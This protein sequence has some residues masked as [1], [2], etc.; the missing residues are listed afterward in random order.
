[1]KICLWLLRMGFR[2][3]VLPADFFLVGFLLQVFSR[4]FPWCS[5]LLVRVRCA[6]AL[7]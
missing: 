3:W 2:L 4:E 1:M 7:L 6:A 5:L